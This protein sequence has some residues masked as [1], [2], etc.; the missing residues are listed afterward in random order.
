MIF[1]VLQRLTVVHF[2]L[3][4]THQQVPSYERLTWVTSRSRVY[5]VISF[6]VTSL[7]RRSPVNMMVCGRKLTSKIVFVSLLCS[8]EF[9]AFYVRYH[10]LT[11]I[12]LKVKVNQS[13]CTA[14]C[15]VQTTLKRS[16]MDHTAF[17]LQRTPC[18]PFLRK[19][20][21]NGASTECGGGYLIAAHYSCIDPERMKGYVGVVGWPIADGLPT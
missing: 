3:Y 8:T 9:W 10:S 17:N 19:C 21:P 4:W 5:L 2:H 15:M 14:P 16:G 7:R 13:T 6:I 11:F 1:C 18:L 12:D 20:S